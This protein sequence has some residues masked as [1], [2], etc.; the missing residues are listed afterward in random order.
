MSPTPVTST[1][2]NLA[3]NSRGC[4]QP[5]S[6]PTASW[7]L[8]GGSLAKRHELWPSVITFPEKLKSGQAIQR[9]IMT[10]GIKV[11]SNN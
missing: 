3:Q 2:M 5:L 4:N 6:P 10:K 9:S 1:P 11:S 8:E 7:V